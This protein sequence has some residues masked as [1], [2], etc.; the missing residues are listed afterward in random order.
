MLYCSQAKGNCI[1]LLRT[2][3]VQ[4]AVQSLL[5]DGDESRQL[6]IVNF[7]KHFGFCF[8]QKIIGFISFI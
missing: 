6:A 8:Q 5:V 2:E 4:G 7:G 1:V 3:V